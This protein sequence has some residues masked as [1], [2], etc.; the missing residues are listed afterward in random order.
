MLR[1]VKSQLRELT[2]FRTAA[3]A[4]AE[5]WN[6]KMKMKASGELKARLQTVKY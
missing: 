6:V 4:V 3:L 5:G 2:L 1:E